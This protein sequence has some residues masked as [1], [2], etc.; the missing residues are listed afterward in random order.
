ML[1]R[2]S[3]NLNRQSEDATVPLIREVLQ[4]GVE[5]SEVNP[6]PTILLSSFAD[7]RVCESDG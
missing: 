3:T 5:L 6:N 1:R 2:P 4:R 7:H